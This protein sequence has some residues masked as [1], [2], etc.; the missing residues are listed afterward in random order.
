M[1]DIYA[2]LKEHLEKGKDWEKL[3]VPVDGVFVVK[4]S[5]TKT[6][7]AILQLKINLLTEDERPMKRKGL[8]VGSKEMLIKFGETLNNEKVEQLI[9]ERFHWMCPCSS[10]LTKN[11]SE[12]P[13]PK[14]FVIPVI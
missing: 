7:P 12:L 5:A 9:A 3:E 10:N 1:A 2:Q 8:F 6:R 13:A 4:G 14:L 11:T